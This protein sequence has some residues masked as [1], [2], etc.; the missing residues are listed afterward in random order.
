MQK[1]MGS[2]TKLL[3]AGVT[4]LSVVACFGAAYRWFELAS[5]FRLQYLL[6]AAFL[7]L[8]FAARRELRWSALAM[9]AAA[10]NAHALMSPSLPDAVA[11]VAAR[12]DSVPVRLLLANLQYSNGAYAEFT[13]LVGDQR[14]DVIVVQEVTPAWA[15][16]LAALDKRYPARKLVAREGAFGIGILSRWPLHD[17]ELWDFGHPAHPAL[18]AHIATG[19]GRLALLAVHPPPPVSAELFA[20]RNDQ[21]HRAAALLRRL[22]TRTVLLGDLNTSPWSPYFARLLEQSGLTS[23][24]EGFGLLPTWPSFFPPAMIP[25]D[26]CLISRDARVAGVKTGPH[27]GSDHLPLVIDL[28]VQD[29]SCCGR[30]SA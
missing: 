7:L 10:L 18:L 1:V 8:V 2:I 5:H 6:A 13:R 22:G 28:L 4:L 14:P 19:S 11:A 16:A 24:R 21:L 15:A 12:P 20:A 3:L 30:L 25:I 17:V 9:G 23:V 26:H 27:I 29:R